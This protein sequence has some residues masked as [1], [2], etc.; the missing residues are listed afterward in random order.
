MAVRG[1]YTGKDCKGKQLKFTHTA[2]GSYLNITT[3]YCQTRG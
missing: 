3:V 1:Q 2:W